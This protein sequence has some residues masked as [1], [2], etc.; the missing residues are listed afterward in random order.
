MKIESRKMK[1]ENRKYEY[2]ICLNL[3]LHVIIH[4]IC[5]HTAQKRGRMYTYS[6]EI[7][8]LNAVCT[9]CVIALLC[10]YVT[11]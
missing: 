10:K 2:F 4:F 9:V 6:S 5:L 8:A 3:N 1:V 7:D 11:E